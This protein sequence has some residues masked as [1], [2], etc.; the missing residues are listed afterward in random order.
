MYRMTASNQTSEPEQPGN[1]EANTS[2][3][4]FVPPDTPSPVPTEEVTPGKPQAI[5]SDMV[6]PDDK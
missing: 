4:T 5:D 3:E 1:E 6:P 2:K